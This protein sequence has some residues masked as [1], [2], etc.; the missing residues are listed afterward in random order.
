MKTLSKVLLVIFCLNQVAF[1]EAVSLAKAAELACHRIERL[2]TLRKIDEKFLNRFYSLEILALPQGGT[3]D[4]AF[5][6]LSSQFPGPDG[7]SNKIEL[8]MDL[9]GK[10]LN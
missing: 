6:I 10:T 1:A 7:N 4:P 8:F 9:N 5:K 3:S 2:V